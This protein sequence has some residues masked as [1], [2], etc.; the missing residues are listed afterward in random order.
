MWRIQAVDIYIKNLSNIFT[1]LVEQALKPER[2]TFFARFS[3]KLGSQ[4]FSRRICNLSHLIVTIQAR[5]TTKKEGTQTRNTRQGTQVA[6]KTPKESFP[7]ARFNNKKNSRRWSGIPVSTAGQA[8]QHEAVH[9]SHA[10][11]RSQRS[12]P[13]NSNL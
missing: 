12:Q 9:P 5:E 7:S 6:A 2:A 1:L 8:A 4:T 13:T 11:A 3:S 10:G